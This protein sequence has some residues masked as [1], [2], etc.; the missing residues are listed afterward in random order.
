MCSNYISKDLNF[1]LCKEIELVEIL[2]KEYDKTITKTSKFCCWD[3]EGDE[4]VIEIK[5]RKNA[6][7]KYPTT[8]IGQN[9]IDKM[10]KLDKKKILI[11]CFTDG[12]Y[13]F[14]LDENSID[15]CSQ[16]CRG[17]RFDRGFN[18]YKSNG[19]CFI[20][21]KHLTLLVATVGD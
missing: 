12:V 7:N 1:G 18:E 17:G 14:I 2:K 3:Y 4:C 8:M 20:P 5:S 13:Y 11:F 19:Y 9:K 10:M 16:N 6:Y 21:I 15:K